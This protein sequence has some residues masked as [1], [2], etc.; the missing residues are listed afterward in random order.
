[1][2]EADV[3]KTSA[4][5]E[6]RQLESRC[7]A[8]LC[9][10]ILPDGVVDAVI[11]GNTGPLT[12]GRCLG[13]LI[14]GQHASAQTAATAPTVAAAPVPQPDRQAISAQASSPVMQAAGNEAAAAINECKSKRL[15][16][17][18]KSFVQSA[19][20]SNPRI[21][22]AFKKANYR[23]LDLVT[24]M[25]AKRMQIAERLDRNQM[26]EADANVAYQQAFT[27]IVTAEKARDAMSK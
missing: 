5:A 12:P 17:E 9:R 27:D 4:P 3:R 7:Q 11:E 23:Y 24:L 21:I 14:G 6:E 19:Q 22:A 13:L 15:S 18:L 26:S 20:C 8:G 16:G 1:V 25:T 2:P 10:V